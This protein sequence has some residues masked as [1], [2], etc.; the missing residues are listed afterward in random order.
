MIKDIRVVEWIEEGKKFKWDIQVLREGSD[1]W[2]PVTCVRLE[3]RPEE[4]SREKN[5]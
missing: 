3:E 1:K 4:I 2:E 5:T